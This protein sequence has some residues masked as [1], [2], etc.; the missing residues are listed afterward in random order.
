MKNHTT[1]GQL[2]NDKLKEKGMKVT[3]LAEK[4]NSSRGNIYDIFKRPN[5]GIDLLKDI[6]LALNHNFFDDLANNLD[7]IGEWKETDETRKEEAIYLLIQKDI[8]EILHELKRCSCIVFTPKFDFPTPDFGLDNYPIYF[9]INETLESRIG[10]YSMLQIEKY[11]SKNGGMI[12][13]GTN[14]LNNSKF[15]NINLDKVFERNELKQLLQ[16]AFN[17]YDSLISKF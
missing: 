4:I 8:P 14:L 9:T 11:R 6:S 7:L 2:I 15:I 10:L 5:I 17:V 3:E 16:F 13:I 1:I 12:E